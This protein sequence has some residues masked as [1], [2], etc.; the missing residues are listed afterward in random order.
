MKSLRHLLWRLLAVML[1][2][3]VLLCL[4]LTWA[5][6]ASPP[7]EAV[8]ESVPQDENLRIAQIV[9]NGEHIVNN[10]R[11]EVGDGVYRRDAHAKTHGCALASFT[12][13]NLF[14]R[15]FLYGVFSQAKTYRAWI[16]FSSGD[17]GVQSDWA[18]DARGM[19]VKLLRVPGKKLLEG[20]ENATTQD[21]L[22]IDNPVFFIRNVEEYVKLTTY[23][24]E[25]LKFAYFFPGKN[26]LNWNMR[27]FRLGL[28]ILGTPPPRNLLR[29][30][31]YSM[32]AY[33]LG[34]AQF[35]KF[36]TKPVACAAGSSLPSSWS[37]F[38]K[39]TLRESLTRQ[40]KSGRYCFDFM[41]QLQDSGPGKYMP[42][43]DVT[44]EWK[45]SQ[46]PF[47]PVARIEID[48]QEIGAPGDAFCENLSFSPWHALPDHEPVGVSTVP[49]RPCIRIFRATAGVPTESSSANQPTTAPEDSLLSH[50]MRGSPCRRLS[51]EPNPRKSRQRSG[52]RTGIYNAPNRSTDKRSRYMPNVI[53]NYDG[54]I[55]TTPRQ[56]I[57]PQTVQEIQSILRDSSTYPTPVRAKGSYH[58]LTPCVSSDGTI[59]DMS[60]MVQIIDIDPANNSFTAQAGLQIIDAS[61]ALREK[62]LQFMTNIEIGNM[63]LGAA[64]CCHSKDA[65]DGIEFGQMNSYVT[66]IKWVT[67]AGELAEASVAGSPDL[68]YLVRSSYGLAGIIYEV[69]FRVKPIEALHFTYL[70]RPVDELTDAEVEQP[71][72]YFRRPDRLD[73][74]TNLRFS[75][76]PARG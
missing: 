32:S 33:R 16:R 68:L 23:Q 27:E 39:D 37:G 44:I 60:H 19:A 51:Q 56:L 25:G 8:G 7:R 65:L 9:D 54:S 72:R 52:N 48:S 5:A 57:Y 26:P 6:Y 21:F 29:T 42:I 58:S 46:S 11:N 66:N 59:I 34:T 67:P 55:T 14:D 35:A 75:T 24:S 62:D 2:A 43:E 61:K 3:L 45:Q 49:A 10:T 1:S 20:E 41:V 22:M 13:K 38:G 36:S 63:T 70:P 47:I 30:Q 71:F 12:V 28:G 69:S 73:R 17:F 40:L 31:F 74:G 4:Y 76:P 50:A 53:V 15:R 18:P 64:A